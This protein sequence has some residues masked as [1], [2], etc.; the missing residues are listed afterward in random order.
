FKLL[1]D[2]DMRLQLKKSEQ[3]TLSYAMQTQFTDV[4]NLAKGIV[5]NNYNSIFSGD[6]TL[7]NALAHNI[8]LRYFSFNM[9]NYTNVFANISYSKKIDQIRNLTNFESVIRTNSPFNSAF[10]D[11]TL[12]AFGRFQRRFGKLQ[13]SVNGN[14]NYSKFNQFIQNQRSVNENYSQTYRAELRTNF[15]EAPNVE[16][17]YSYSISDNDQGTSRSKFYTKAPSIDVDALLLKTL[18]FKTDYTYNNFS[19]NNGTINDYQFWNASLSYRKDKDAKLE[20]EV[21]AT[22][23]L[24]TKSQNQS[25][26]SNISVSATEYYIQPLYVTFRLIYSL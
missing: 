11:E 23:L 24:N 25:N 15:K 9:F 2:F 5:L 20:Y 7:D 12:S 16:L 18:T 17:G 22:N 21:K 3:I 14:F 1:P 8:S 19:D 10:A 13:A 26:T 6:A 4:N